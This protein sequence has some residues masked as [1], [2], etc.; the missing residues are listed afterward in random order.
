M[1]RPPTILTRRHAHETYLSAPVPVG[2]INVA[3]S[4]AAADR[5]I[6]P[7]PDQIEVTWNGA[8]A[9]NTD[10][11]VIGSFDGGKTWVVLAA[12]AFNTGYTAG[13]DDEDP[14]HE[15]RFNFQSDT[16]PTG[17]AVV[18]L[19]DGTP[20]LDADD[21][22]ETEDLDAAMMNSAFI[23]RVQARQPGVDVKVVATEDVETWKTSNSAD[24]EAKN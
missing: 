8:R 12:N 1:S 17:L 15:Y 6:D 10:A 18:S 3:P 9:G 11:R 16:P 19:A 4:S 24:V 5:D 21:N 23:I 20:V 14:D 2:A 22:A 7:D 13:A